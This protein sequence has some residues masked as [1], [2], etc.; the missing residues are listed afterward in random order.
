MFDDDDTVKA[1]EGK[2][3]LAATAFGLRDAMAKGFGAM[4][5][6]A[7]AIAILAACAADTSSWYPSGKAEIASFQ[8]YASLGGKTCVVTIEITNTGKSLINSCTISIS[9]VTDLRTYKRTISENLVILPEKRVFLDMEIA[10][11]SEL[12]ALEPSGL[13]IADEFY[14]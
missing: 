1:P 2:G 14:L 9:A 10:Y 12:E 13:A 8:E 3:C 7:C 5:A 4:A 6:L 11:L